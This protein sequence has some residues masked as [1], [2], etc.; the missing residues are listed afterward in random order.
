MYA[1]C[2]SEFAIEELQDLMTSKL[3]FKNQLLTSFDIHHIFQA[4]YYSGLPCK[5][6]FY[7]C[8]FGSLTLKMMAKWL[9]PYSI[10]PSGGVGSEIE[11]CVHVCVHGG[12]TSVCGV[13][14]CVH[15]CMVDAPVCVVCVYVHSGCTRWC[16]YVCVCLWR[17][18]GCRVLGVNMSECHTSEMNCDFSYI[19]LLLRRA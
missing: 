17:V 3:T 15:M 14:M 19:L 11:V 2:V 7:Q 13:C 9:R 1:A 16:V 4:V 8:L 10:L 12:C 6:E 18:N 5:L